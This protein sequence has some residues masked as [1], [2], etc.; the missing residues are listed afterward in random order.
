MVENNQKVTLF[1]EK[2]AKDHD[3]KERLRRVYE[4]YTDEQTNAMKEAIG[5]DMET[6]NIKKFLKKEQLVT[7]ATM[8]KSSSF[9]H[10]VNQIKKEL[11]MDQV[12]I[13]IEEF[14]NLLDDNKAV[15]ED[16]DEV[17]IAR[18]QFKEVGDSLK[19]SLLISTP[20][21]IER[22]LLQPTKSWCLLVYA[23]YQTNMEEAPVILFGANTF[24]SGKKFDGIGAVI[25]SIRL[26]AAVCEGFAL[27]P[28]HLTT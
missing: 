23:T 14:K 13:T 12:K 19:F 17:Y 15:S 10:K 1:D 3:H 27:R 5:L 7:D 11:K 20:R 22:N 25:S 2:E 24:Q 16:K 26:F 9:Y 21:L 4:N 28:S 18:A 8:P 6:R